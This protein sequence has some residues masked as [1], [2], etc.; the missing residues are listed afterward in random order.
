MPY[1]D[2][3]AEVQARNQKVNR[4]NMLSD[5]FTKLTRTRAQLGATEEIAIVTA[6]PSGTFGENYGYKCPL[7]SKEL[8][9]GLAP[10][11]D[12]LAKAWHARTC[13]KNRG[14]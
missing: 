3:D 1:D 5:P 14:G 13:E 10:H 12:R 9:A 2:R 11:E 6:A 8:P 4:K 7:C